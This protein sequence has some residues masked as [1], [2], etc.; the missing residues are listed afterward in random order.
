MTD[1]PRIGLIG[2]TG[3]EGL[4][5]ALRLVHAGVPVLLGSRSQD[6]AEAAAGSLRSRVPAARV[7]PAENGVVIASSDILVLSVQFAGAEATIAEHR[8]RFRPG[9]LLIDLTVPVAF[10]GGRPRFVELA[11]GSSAEHIRARLPE[12][13]ALGVALKTIPAHALAAIDRPLDCDDFICGDTEDARARTLEFVR[14]IP[15]LRGV[16]CGALDAARVLERM[17]LLA[18]TLNRRYKTQGA[19]FRVV[20]LP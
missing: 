1:S 4:G 9:S 6:R 7:E 17:T 14:L 3:R 16:D 2:G 10:E 11:E 8:H 18:I 19:R 12:S 13:V 15:G 5:V 20:G